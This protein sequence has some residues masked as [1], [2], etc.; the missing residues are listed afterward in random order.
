MSPLL[1]LSQ[2][3]RDKVFLDGS[4]QNWVGRGSEIQIEPSRWGLLGSNSEGL[5]LWVLSRTEY[6]VAPQNTLAVWPW[7]WTRLSEMIFR[8]DNNSHLTMWLPGLSQGMCVGSHSCKS[9]SRA[10]GMPPLLPLFYCCQLEAETAMLKSGKK[11]AAAEA[12]PASHW[13]HHPL[14]A[15]PSGSGWALL[16]TLQD[17]FLRLSYCPGC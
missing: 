4:S 11:W 15:V 9:W 13:P 16:S 2:I 14:R 3:L 17:A 12:W 1:P 8:A 10:L 5:R 6:N 7:A